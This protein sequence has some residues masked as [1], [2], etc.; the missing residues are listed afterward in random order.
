MPARR[1]LLKLRGPT[2]WVWAAEA[3]RGQVTRATLHDENR[4]VIGLEYDGEQYTVT[5]ERHDGELFEGSWLCQDG[6]TGGASARLYRSESNY[7]LFGEWSAA[8]ER[9]YWWA[10]LCS[11]KHFPDE[12]PG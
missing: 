3:E 10:E 2:R 9:Q 5:L 11:V 4:L 6:S 7:L 1:K 8:G 12:V